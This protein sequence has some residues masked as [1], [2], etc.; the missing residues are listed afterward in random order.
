MSKLLFAVLF[1]A[2]GVVVHGQEPAMRAEPADQPP[3]ATR[4]QT[5]AES[6][7]K[8]ETDAPA[9]VAPA[10]DPDPPKPA[11]DYVNPDSK[12]RFKMYLDDVA[13][14][15]SLGYYVGTAGLLTARNSPK[16][17]GAKFDGFGYRVANVAG[18]HVIKTST[19]YGL[20]RL[21]KLDSTFHPSRDRSVT[22]RLRNSVFSS[23]TA[24][25]S[26]GE[27]VLGIPNIVGGTAA[28]VISSTMWYP[29]RYDYIHGLKG[30]AISIGMSAGFNLVREFLWK[31]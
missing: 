14:P 11:I 13:G 8:P 1:A 9:I 4:P 26:R 10:D 28:E 20:D 5:L 3:T 16:E 23:V 21:L 17:W 24:R 18:K 30:G 15:V 6:G 12:S 25:N 31:P 19:A 29:S 22:A 27:R 7:E 2:F